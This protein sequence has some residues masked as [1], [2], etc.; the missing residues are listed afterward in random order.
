MTLRGDEPYD[1]ALPAVIPS[2]AHGREGKIV[3]E[4]EQ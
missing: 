2:S 1:E 4:K 3:Q